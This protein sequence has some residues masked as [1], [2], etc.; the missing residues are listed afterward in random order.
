MLL[1]THASGSAPTPQALLR[2]SRVD[3][4]QGAGGGLHPATAMEQV[5]GGNGV[6]SLPAQ[7]NMF[8]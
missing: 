4:P 1:K 6:H 7:E 2:R 3:G 5:R 8:M